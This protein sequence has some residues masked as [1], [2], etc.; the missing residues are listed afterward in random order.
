MTATRPRPP[1][2]GGSTSVEVR[3]AATQEEVRAACALRRRVFCDEQHVPLREEEDGRDAG[4][5]HLVAVEQGSVL[6][7]CRLIIASGVVQLSRLAV[8]SRARRRGIAQALLAAADDEARAGD[9]PR[10]LLHAQTYAR[11]LYLAAGYAAR[12]PLFF[13]AG[14]EHVAMEKRIA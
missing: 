4:A 9:A 10:I 5:L 6:G 8:E 11:G 3:R 14:I 2:G 12:G 13:E 1:T 7:T